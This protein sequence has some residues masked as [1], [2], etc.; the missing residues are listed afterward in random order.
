MKNA[1]LLLILLSMFSFGQMKGQAQNS[2]TQDRGA[3]ING[4]RWATRNVG[5]MGTFVAAPEMYGNL[6]SYWRAID[7]CPRGWRVPT[8]AEFESLV[9]AGSVWTTVGGVNGRTFGVG[10]NSIFLPAA[11]YRDAGNGMIDFSGRLGGYWSSSEHG[12]FAHFLSFD[13][14]SVDPANFIVYREV[15]YAVRCVAD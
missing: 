13:H 2:D 7:V 11:G 8:Q 10:A 4:V 15:G 1:T 5:I 3:V 14:G 6:Y 9:A 12:V